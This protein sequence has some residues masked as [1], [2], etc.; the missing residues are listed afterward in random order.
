[1]NQQWHC[2]CYFLSKKSRRLINELLYAVSCGQWGTY[3][4]FLNKVSPHPVSV[5]IFYSQL[6]A[7]TELPGQLKTPCTSR[8]CASECD[9]STE[10]RIWTEMTNPLLIAEGCFGVGNFTCLQ[11]FASVGKALKRTQVKWGLDCGFSCPSS[12]EQCT[13]TLS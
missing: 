3:C 12:L 1:M 11:I 10:F 7:G 4:I 8:I 13:T 6:G 2:L 5:S 9:G